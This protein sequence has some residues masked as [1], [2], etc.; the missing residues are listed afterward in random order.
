MKIVLRHTGNFLGSRTSKRLP[1]FETVDS[2]RSYELQLIDEIE[3]S[4]NAVL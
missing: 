3:D 4:W 2:F 1:P